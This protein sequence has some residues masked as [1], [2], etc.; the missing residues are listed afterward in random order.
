VNLNCSTGG[1]P[2]VFNVSV[3]EDLREAAGAAGRAGDPA[4]AAPTTAALRL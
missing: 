3:T 2:S 4:G 1:Y